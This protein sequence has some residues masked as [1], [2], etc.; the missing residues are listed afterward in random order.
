MLIMS[1][2]LKKLVCIIVII[3]LIQVIFS[4]HF[5]QVRLQKLYLHNTIAEINNISILLKNKAIA[6]QD[7][8]SF[9]NKSYVIKLLYDI[10]SNS[11][12]VFCIKNKL[13][14]SYY[15]TIINRLVEEIKEYI[16][17]PTEEHLQWIV[18][19]LKQLRKAYENT[20]SYVKNSVVLVPFYG[21]NKLSERF[22]KEVH[23]NLNSILE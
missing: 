9:I 3:I 1:Y 17:N 4:L 15:F 11:M 2:K 20:L 6:S 21:I 22:V 13:F 7:I 12:E 5:K 19:S 14:S 18:F 16:D 10:K 8:N 23:L